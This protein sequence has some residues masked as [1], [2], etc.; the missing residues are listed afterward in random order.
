M[1]DYPIQTQESGLGNSPSS[2]D[3]DIFGSFKGDCYGI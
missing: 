1:V 3:T 2:F